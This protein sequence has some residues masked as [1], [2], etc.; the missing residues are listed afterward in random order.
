MDLRRLH[1]VM[2]SMLLVWGASMRAGENLL[3]NGSFEAYT[4]NAFGYSFEDWSYPLGC[5]FAET[6]E[7]R[8]R[9]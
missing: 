6:E 1:I 7:P 4:S 2:M 3:P 9:R 8:R 5:G